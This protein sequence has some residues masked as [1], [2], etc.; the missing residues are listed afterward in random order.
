M[1]KPMRSLTVAAL[2]T[3]A[4]VFSAQAADAITVVG[5]GGNW[6]KAYKEGVWDKYTEQTGTKIVQEEWGGEL[7]KVRA[8]VQSGSVTW[9]IVSPE[10]PSVAQHPLDIDVLGDADGDDSSPNYARSVAERTRAVNVLLDG[11]DVDMQ[12]VAP[13]FRSLVARRPAVL[14]RHG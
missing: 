3:A 13:P 12:P 4:G 7:A 9:D 6:D 1:Q 10:A 8:Q 5:W 2:L 14:S 11:S